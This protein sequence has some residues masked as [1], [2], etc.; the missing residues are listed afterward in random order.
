MRM[1]TRT[2]FTDDSGLPPV[3]HSTTTT[4]SLVHGGEAEW[5]KS[6]D[7]CPNTCGEIQHTLSLAS[8][9]LGDGYGE[10]DTDKE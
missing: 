8:L 9:E 7:C 1:M 10:S 3:L 4:Q 5:V 2:I 6:G